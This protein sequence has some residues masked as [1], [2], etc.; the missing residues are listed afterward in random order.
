MS[1]SLRVGFS[2]QSKS[3]RDERKSG[4][5]SNEEYKEAKKLWLIRMQEFVKE[6]PKF[7]EL[8]HQLGLYEDRN[9]A[10]RCK[11]RLQNATIPTDAK[12]PII[13][14]QDNYQ[15]DL[16]IRECHHRVLHNG[17]KETLT[18]LRTRFWLV[19]GRQIARKIVSKCFKCKRIEGKHYP[20][21][22]FAPLPKRTRHLQILGS[23]LL[24][25]CMSK[26]PRRNLTMVVVRFISPCIRV[27][28]VELCI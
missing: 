25:L 23:I 15:T 11:G 26:H 8:N 3:K 17:V 27:V 10:L 24:G 13:L 16:I 21:P 9:K 12:H 20:L 4:S 14:P 18:E 22:K 19:R 1:Y 6:S 7:K 5:V 2:A 28:A